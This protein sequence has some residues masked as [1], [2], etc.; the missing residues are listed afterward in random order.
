MTTRISPR[1]FI[2][3]STEHGPL[4]LNYLDYRMGKEG[5]VD[6]GVGHRLL[7]HG[8]MSQFEINAGANLLSWR[9]EAYGDGCVAL[10]CGAN[11][12][13]MT[14]EW[15]KHMAGW[16][17]VIAIEAQERIFY[18][19]AGNICLSNCFNARAIHA[20][21]GSVDGTMSIPQPDYTKPGSF[22]S[23]E[24]RRRKETEF[25]GQSIDYAS[26]KLLPIP[27]LRIDSLSLPRLDLLKIDVEGMEE[28]VLDG[29]QETI[30][31]SHPYIIVEYVKVGADQ[32][33]KRLAE[34][35]YEATQADF[36]FIALPKEDKNWARIQ[37][38]GKGRDGTG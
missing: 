31:R 28:A 33:A 26:D 10:D 35:G 20:A 37:T 5:K 2:L 14:I 19:L 34:F 22:G 4:I 12:G 16:G 8:T 9:R 6:A 27:A 36:N 17:N 32:L 23:L 21:V 11:I 13:G 1:P 3:A 18:A 7:V 25:I 29:A 15:A 30:R 24:L 38:V